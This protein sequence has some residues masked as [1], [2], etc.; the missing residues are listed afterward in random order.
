MRRQ[1]VKRLDTNPIRSLSCEE[2]NEEIRME[3]LKRQK[4]EARV[5]G[6]MGSE[7]FKNCTYNTYSTASDQKS[8]LNESLGNDYNTLTEYKINK[9]DFKLFSS[10]IKQK[11]SLYYENEAY[12]SVKKSKNASFIF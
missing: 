12:G 11:S 7:N 1:S 9:N 3:R 2:I 10:Q 6:Y 8:N 4:K 5:I